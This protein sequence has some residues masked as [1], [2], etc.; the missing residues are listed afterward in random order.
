MEIGDPHHL[1][2]PRGDPGA[3]DVWLFVGEKTP[4][5]IP[6]RPITPPC[7]GPRERAFCLYGHKEYP[8]IAVSKKDSLA[9]R[10]ARGSQ[11]GR[12]RVKGKRFSTD[13]QPKRARGRPKGATNLIT[14]ELKEAIL[15]GAADCGEDGKGKGGL[16]GYL[17][18]VAIEDTK[19]MGMLLRAILPA[20]VKVEVT[21]QKTYPSLDE[22][23]ARLAQLGIPTDNVYRFEHYIGP[24]IEA[25]PVKSE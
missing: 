7:Y 4:A 24:L 12:R 19:T 22:V 8:E 16:R 10:L 2:M 6:V 17:K 14:R 3:R 9:A 13:D 21:E 5:S 23:K 20:N 15:G 25:E 1:A 18:R 11:P